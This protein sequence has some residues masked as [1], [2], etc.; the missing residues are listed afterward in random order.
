MG[1]FTRAHHGRQLA[2]VAD[3]DKSPGP[4]GQTKGQRFGELAGLI[5]DRHFESPTPDVRHGAGT[6]RGGGD[7]RSCIHCQPDRMNPAMLQREILGKV[8]A[9][10]TCSLKPRG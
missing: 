10:I 4:Q 7:N 8:V 3:E 6:M 5:H 1:K 9:R 2:V